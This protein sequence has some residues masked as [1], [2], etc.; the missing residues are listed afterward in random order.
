MNPMSKASFDEREHLK[1]LK[2]IMI[3][4]PYTIKMGNKKCKC[5]G[6][7]HLAEGDF[8]CSGL[9]TRCDKCKNQGLGIF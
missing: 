5:G 3:E 6:T 9:F 7:M 2:E 4:N 8:P 1:K